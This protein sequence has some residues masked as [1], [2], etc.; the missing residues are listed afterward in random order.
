MRVLDVKTSVK[1]MVAADDVVRVTHREI[2]KCFRRCFA[3]LARHRMR[4]FA[5]FRSRISSCWLDPAIWLAGRT[6]RRS[7]IGRPGTVAGRVHWVRTT[8]GVVAAG[9]TD[10]LFRGQR[11]DGQATR[12][13]EW[14][15]G[16]EQRRLANWNVCYAACRNV[17]PS[18]GH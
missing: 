16:V 6:A 1:V 4:C 10:G 5:L 11:R 13:C 8:N 18:N 15:G 9:A 14:R 17:M 3:W 7:L 12:G 2:S